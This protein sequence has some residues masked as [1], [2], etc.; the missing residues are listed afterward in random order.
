MTEVKQP[1]TKTAQVIQTMFPVLDTPQS[2]KVEYEVGMQLFEDEP[3]GTFDE[4]HPQAETQIGVNGELAWQGDNTNS[5]P[6]DDDLDRIRE[7]IE[8]T[9][10][11]LTERPDQNPPA[12]A[13][14]RIS[15]GS[16]PT[17]ACRMLRAA[18]RADI[19]H[20]V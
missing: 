18:G 7:C 15:V 4:N 3:R 2:G 17:Q 20:L 9:S 13:N 8:Y 16:P 1:R 14:I 6:E 11:Y 5:D 12:T 19:A 10:K